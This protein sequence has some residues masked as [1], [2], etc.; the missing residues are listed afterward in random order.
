MIDIDLVGAVARVVP[1]DI[2]A[3][4]VD[5]HW[6]G[7]ANSGKEKQSKSKK[8]C[9]ILLG[10]TTEELQKNHDRSFPFKLNLS[11]I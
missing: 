1:H 4:M 5:E 7:G 9:H 6:L 3:R 2:Q 8:K 11:N 10:I